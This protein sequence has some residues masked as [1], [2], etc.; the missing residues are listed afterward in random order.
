M[1]VLV[2][3]SWAVLKA[4]KPTHMTKIQAGDEL[5]S[6]MNSGGLNMHLAHENH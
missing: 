6:P 3:Y 5:H 4:R 1:T 2:R